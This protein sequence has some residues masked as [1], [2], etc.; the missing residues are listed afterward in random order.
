MLKFSNV[1]QNDFTK[2]IRQ[3]NKVELNKYKENGCRPI[4]NAALDNKA[5]AIEEFYNNELQS[6]MNNYTRDIMRYKAKGGYDSVV[7]ESKTKSTT[8]LELVKPK[9]MPTPK[10]RSESKARFIP[11]PL[12]LSVP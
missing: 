6:L 3:W 7:K 11:A 10:T 5:T 12:A 8:D 4:L 2:G 9:V 1:W